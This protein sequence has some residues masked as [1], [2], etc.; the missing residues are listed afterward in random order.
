MCASL[1]YAFGSTP[2]V[3]TI[4][5]PAPDAVVDPMSNLTVSW[6]PISGATCYVLYVGS[7]PGTSNVFASPQLTGSSFALPLLLPANTY[8][9][10]LW[11][12]INGGWFYYDRSFKT[13]NGIARILSPA[14]GAFQLDPSYPIPISWTTTPDAT[15]YYLYVGTQ[16]GLSDVFASGKVQS[17]S[18]NVQ[19][20]S[21][22]TYYVRIFTQKGTA[23]YYTDSTFQTGRAN[24]IITSPGR[25]ATGIS[26]V[27]PVPVTW[28]AVPD[29]LSYT[30]YVGTTQGG[31]NVWTSGTIQATSANVPLGPSTK[32]YLRLFTQKADGWH[33]EDTTLTTT[34]TI[35]K[36][37]APANHATG[38]DPTN[39]VTILWSSITDAV[40]YYLY[41]GS[42]VGASDIYASGQTQST[43]VSRSLSP[44]T[45]YY[46]RIWTIKANNAW[47]YT[48]SV[49]T[50]GRLNAKVISPANG[51]TGI[52]PTG[53]VP[54]QWSTVSDASN[55]Y[56]Y[57]GTTKGAS[58]AYSSGLVTASSVSPRLNPN[59]T[60]YLRLFTVVGGAWFYEDST[61]TT[62]TTFSRLVTPANGAT[63]DPNSPVTFTW[64]SITDA[65]GYS[66]YI[67]TAPGA[68]D[69]YNSGTITATSTSVALPQNS[70]YY[71]RLTTLKSTGS[72][73]HDYTI[74][75]GAL[76]SVLINPANGTSGV[77]PTG[78]T[79]FN[80]TSIPDATGYFLYLG[81]TPGASDVFGSGRIAGTSANV[82][83][84]PGATYYA[85]IFTQKG[86]AWYY[87]DSSL[88]TGGVRS[89]LVNPPDHSSNVDPFVSLTWNPMTGASYYFLTIGTGPG[90]TDVYSSGNIAASSTTVTPY[91]LIPGKSY[92]VRLYTVT[93]GGWLF[94]DSVFT[95][96]AGD[97]IDSATLLGKV[98]NLTATVRNMADIN[99]TT[100]VGT[101]LYTVVQARGKTGADCADFAVTLLQSLHDNRV[102]A[103]RRDV[104]FDGFDET[105]TIAEYYDP[106]LQKWGIAD[107]TFGLLYNDGSPDSMLSVEDISSSILAMDFDIPKDFVTSQKDYWYRNDLLDPLT[108]YLNPYSVQGSRPFT[109]NDFHPYVSG[110]V[111]GQVSGINGIYKFEFAN[112]TDSLNLASGT[113]V[114]PAQT[115]PFVVSST[116]GLPTNWV[117]AVVPSGMAT[118]TYTR[119]WTN[120]ATI[121]SP[122]P[123][124]K[125]QTPYLPL[126]VQWTEIHNA[127]GYRVL[128]GSA[129]GASDLFDSGIVT[130][131]TAWVQAGPATT[132]YITLFTY[133]GDEVNESDSTFQTQNI[134][135]AQLLSPADGS[136]VSAG[137]IAFQWNPAADAS[138]Y[139]FYVGTTQGAYDIYRSSSMTVTSKSVSIT[140]TGTF[141]VRLWTLVGSSWYFQDSTVTIH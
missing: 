109:I 88:T 17:S 77:D 141:F 125:L 101:P 79:T 62:G 107:P 52:D 81:T 15:A 103:R 94:H 60:Y 92:Y 45:T 12:N 22:T 34:T 37:T 124:P 100:L 50:T 132:Y 24:A 3:A 33:Y 8:Y 51:A 93:A 43:S 30:L 99:N 26:P 72:Y 11:T 19:L 83:L 71:V 76:K 139:S 108:Y 36:I 127:T 16:K 20:G 54:I 86:T 47:S 31:S 21:S 18:A 46:L 134:S 114:S 14:N 111:L 123:Y 136:T 119:F 56:L 28:T 73:V 140:K 53:P 57:V 44:N 87:T 110:H 58:D 70:T 23:W 35:S 59:T 67:G 112:P 40:S 25:N 13:A 10:R 126:A 138:A 90:L 102:I 42:S 120:T 4:T 84:T 117:P 96:G 133:V 116:V 131:T 104:T 78:P 98:E 39:P 91:G 48:D 5:S 106:N 105:H 74:K 130:A 7:S 97:N 29:A 113:K 137:T 68:S 1:S 135:I 85:R 9:V 6:T 61:L 64:S 129:P 89:H 27:N 32:Y 121:T 95:T 115:T 118:Y 75:T 49:F 69:I 122:K 66:L 82:Q 41:V 55:Y 128:V 38:I 80:W 2:T 65:L 63:V